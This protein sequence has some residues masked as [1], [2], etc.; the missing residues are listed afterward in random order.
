MRRW[1]TS[2]DRAASLDVLPAVVRA[3]RKFVLIWTE[4]V[5]W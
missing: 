5:G 2:V 1:P 4:A 3:Y